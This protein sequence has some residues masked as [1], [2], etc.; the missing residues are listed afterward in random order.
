MSR[1][2]LVVYSLLLVLTSSCSSNKSD[3]NNSPNLPAVNPGSPS[4]QVYVRAKAEF[5]LSSAPDGSAQFNLVKKT[6]AAAPNCLHGQCTDYSDITVTNEGS[7]QFQLAQ[8]QAQINQSTSNQNLSNIVDLKIATLFD[9][10]LTS[11]G[12]QKCESA[13]IRIYTTD[14][15]GI[16]GAGL[17]SQAI[18]QS[19]PLTVSG[20]S[21]NSIL[22]TIPYFSAAN[23]D[24]GRDLQVDL[25][26]LAVD[27]N[28]LSLQMAD[29]A[30][31]SPSGA[32]YILSADFT[33]AG[34][35]SYKAHVVV[36]YDLIASPTIAC[37]IPN[38]TGAK[39]WNGS[40]YGSCVVTSCSSNFVLENNSCDLP[41]A[42]APLSNNILIN[43]TIQ[44]SASGGISPYTWSASGS[45]SIDSSSGLFTASSNAGAASVTVTDN[46]GVSTSAA[47]IVYSPLIVSSI[48]QS[49]QPNTT[50]QMTASGGIAPYIW[51]ATGAGTINSSGLITAGANAGTMVVTATDSQLNQASETITVTIPLLTNLILSTDKPVGLVQENTEL[52][53]FSGG[54]NPVTYDQASTGS[55]F[56]VNDMITATLTATPTNAS[57]IYSVIPTSIGQQSSIGPSFTFP[58]SLLTASGN[59][60]VTGTS[61]PAAITSNIIPIKSYTVQGISNL[62]HFM[63]LNP[64]FLGS[65]NSTLVFSY[66]SADTNKLKLVSYSLITN[67]ASA[68]SNGNPESLSDITSSSNPVVYNNMIYYTG[69]DSTVANHLYATDGSVVTQISNITNSPGNGDGIT[70]LTAANGLL[71]FNAFGDANFKTKLWKF[72]GTNLTQ[73]PAT[74]STGNDAPSSIVGDGTNLYYSAFNASNQTKL[75]KYNGTTVTQMSNTNTSGSD[76]ISLP[77][78]NGTIIYFVANNPSNQQ[79][80]WKCDGTT[81]T[82]VSNTDT[83]NTD[84]PANLTFIGSTLYFSA[85]K[86]TTGSVMKLYKYVSGSVTQVSNTNTNT[87]GSDNPGN[88]RVIGTNLYFTSTGNTGTTTFTKL[89]V[90]NGTTV[91]QASNLNTSGSDSFSNLT[92]I[93]SN[94]YFNASVT[95]VTSVWS[96]SG[97]TCSG[98]GLTATCSGF[99]KVSDSADVGTPST[100][101]GM[102]GVLYYLSFQDGGSLGTVYSYNGSSYSQIPETSSSVTILAASPVTNQLAYTVNGSTQLKFWDIASNSSNVVIAPTQ[103]NFVTDLPLSMMANGSKLYFSANDEVGAQKMFMFDDSNNAITQISNTV[104]DQEIPDSPGFT[105]IMNGILYFTSNNSLNQVKLYKY[106]GTNVTQVSNTTPTGTDTPNGLTVLGSNLYFASYAAS[107]TLR[108]LYKYDGTNLTQVSNTDPTGTDSPS[109]MTLVGSNVYFTASNPTG[110][111]KVWKYD[112]T[113][114]TQVPA[115]NTSGNDG[116]SE[117]TVVGSNLYYVSL[118]SSAQSKVWKFDGTTLTQVSNSNPSGSDNPGLLTVSGSNLYYVS[119]NSSSQSKVWKYDGTTSTQISNGVPSGSDNISNLLAVGSNLYY[120]GS[121]TSGFLKLWMYNGTNTP[122]Q[123]SNTN[124]TGTDSPSLP[125]AIGSNIYFS[126]L[127]PLSQ[128]KLW[129]YNGTSVNQLSNINPTSNDL[130]SS[131]V[132][133]GSTVYF[134]GMNANNVAKLFL[135]DGTIPCTGS[136]ST[137]VCNGTLQI[138]NTTNSNTSAD[139]SAPV[140]VG[141]GQDVF[142]PANSRQGVQKI[143]RIHQN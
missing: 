51:S 31:A 94:L 12:G 13:A 34:A 134:Q 126:A 67:S 74:N 21:S 103:S 66:T 24:N 113:N 16:Q 20:G 80:I 6:Y 118:N 79:K 17:W 59:F 122:T 43:N 27:K 11:C 117:L 52:N 104:G 86:S 40:S 111:A 82:Q 136:G 88:I 5:D 35:A 85:L 87:N 7:T 71:Y 25:D 133:I 3:S 119:S 108:K 53:L 37:V 2:N 47:V 110:Q 68:L 138:T 137:A 36:E 83:S 135:T 127:N 63:K 125:V 115:T 14:S 72:D 93:G 75:W 130:P 142:F 32:G 141:V 55:V 139:V 9:N 10:N 100:I 121:N 54:S 101:I 97:S 120:S 129:V 96:S 95:G 42:M 114:V 49:L 81:V 18:G 1:K 28:V 102:N 73:V 50:L 112:G 39:S 65:V 123:I 143:Y 48:T 131:L 116:A 105:A 57:S 107:T 84:A 23:P 106:D 26:P 90:Y 45:G 30:D 38:G 128:T 91:T 99:T 69:L 58:R 22:A 70:N 33:K 140:M 64:T 8:S 132:A 15:T 19:V 92:L 4:G 44:F 29:F 46:F 98:T 61:S 77:I 78:V 89:Y 60:S 62:D 56:D 109:N 41:L 124:T 76:S